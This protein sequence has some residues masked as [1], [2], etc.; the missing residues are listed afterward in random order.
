MRDLIWRAAVATVATAVLVFGVFVPVAE[1]A[2]ATVLYVSQGGLDSGNC[3]SASP[4]ATVS[5]ALTRAA[6]G[7]TIHISGTIDDHLSI[8]RRVTITRWFGGPDGSRAVLDGTATGTVVTVG[9]AVTGVT[10]HD[11]TIENGAQ[12]ISSPGFGTTPIVRLT[13]STVSGNSGFGG[14]YNG[15][16]MTIIDSTIANN[17]NTGNG[18]SGGIDNHGKMTVI[19]STISGNRVVNGSGVGG[20]YSALGATLTLGAT[21]VA[22]NPGGNCLAGNGALVSAGYN[23]TNDR[24]RRAC[25]LT[26]VSDRVN[27]QP[28]LGTLARNGGPTR[29]M[30]PAEGGPADDA[31]PKTTKLRGVTVC[32]GADQRGVARPG[33]NDRRC[34]IGAVEV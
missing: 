9:S 8:S 5:F 3:T 16:T 6:S 32:P 26:A 25:K 29:T 15:G 1:A 7:A 28:N 12:G 19:A 11:L 4:C 20:L 2:P 13:D 23:L 22:H 24:I 17:T 31:I 10:L 33:K 34:T 30:L 27:T 14:I 18:P 21:V